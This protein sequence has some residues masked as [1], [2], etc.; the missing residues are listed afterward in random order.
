[1]ID[2]RPMRVFTAS[3]TCTAVLMHLHPQRSQ[4]IRVYFYCLLIFLSVKTCTLLISG[5]YCT[6]RVTKYPYTLFQQ[7]A[8]FLIS[9]FTSSQVISCFSA[10]FQNFH[11]DQISIRT[12]STLFYVHLR[13]IY[14]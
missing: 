9:T 12:S 11:I 13:L 7:T 6:G 4:I 5:N 10:S 14:T 8:R 2:L 1:M 3:Y